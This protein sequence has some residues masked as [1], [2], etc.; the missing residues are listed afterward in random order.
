[1]RK[2]ASV[3]ALEEL[4]RVRL[5]E[6][7]FMRDFLH[8]EIASHYGIA[9]VP[10]DPDLAV[11]AGTILCETLLEPIVAT[12]GRISIRSAFRSLEVNG[13]GNARGHNC[14]SS[15]SNFGGHIWDRRDAD[16]RIGATACIIVHAFIPYYERTGDWEAIAWWMHDHLPYSELEFFPRFCAFNIGWRDAPRRRIRSYIPPRMGVLTKAGMTNQAGSHAV[17]YADWLASL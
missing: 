10:D 17:A 15:E 7:F 16:G 12:F 9:N 11:A 14:G 6:N 1:M 3:K 8:S 13:I 2:P 5:S 4:G